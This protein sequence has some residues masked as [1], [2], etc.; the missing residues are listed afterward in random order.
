MTRGRGWLRL[1]LW[2]G[3]DKQKSGVSGG[4]MMMVIAEVDGNEEE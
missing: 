2:G 4:A 3:I 1:W